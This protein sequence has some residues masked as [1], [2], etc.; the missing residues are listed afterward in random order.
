MGS[1]PRMLDLF[2]EF[3]LSRDGEF[4]GLG[5]GGTVGLGASEGDGVFAGED[6]AGAFGIDLG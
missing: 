3:G 6:G 4:G 2:W 5:G 1:V